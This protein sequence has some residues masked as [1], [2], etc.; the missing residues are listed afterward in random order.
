M[1]CRRCWP[2][3]NRDET[4]VKPACWLYGKPGWHK[5]NRILPRPL[6]G[7]RKKVPRHL[8]SR[9]TKIWW[10]LIISYHTLQ[11]CDKSSSVLIT[12]LSSS[13]CNR[14]SYS[15]IL[16]TDESHGHGA[17]PVK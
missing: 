5:R 14:G 1:L 16:T 12:Q 7:S 17:V 11:T 2:R 4:I 3:M 10:R 15:V 9:G 8:M 13:G 6:L